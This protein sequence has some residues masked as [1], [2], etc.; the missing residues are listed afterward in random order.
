[1]KNQFTYLK[2][3]GHIIELVQAMGWSDAQQTVVPNGYRLT[4]EGPN[5]QLSQHT[6]SNDT[7]WICK[8][9]DL[10]IE[11]GFGGEII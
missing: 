5:V 11:G 4:V 2:Y 1:M 8:A 10:K 9:I 3:K 7:L 6:Y